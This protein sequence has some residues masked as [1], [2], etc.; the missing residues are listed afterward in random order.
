MLFS[1]LLLSE[2]ERL[3]FKLLNLNLHDPTIPEA[4]GCRVPVFDLFFHT[5]LFQHK[6]F[7]PRR[8]SLSLCRTQ[9]MNELF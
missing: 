2:N 9:S 1:I 4:L 7:L 8:F 6:H 5:V 3:R